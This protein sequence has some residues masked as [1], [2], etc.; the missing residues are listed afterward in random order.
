MIA[1][2]GTDSTASRPLACREMIN[3]QRTRRAVVES[4]WRISSG[5]M[6][7]GERGWDSRWVSIRP[8]GRHCPHLTGPKKEGGPRAAP[9]NG[10]VSET[11]SLLDLVA[12][13]APETKRLDG[14]PRHG[15]RPCLR[16]VTPKVPAAPRAAARRQASGA[17]AQ[18]FRV[19]INLARSSPKNGRRPG[20]QVPS[21]KDVRRNDGAVRLAR[22]HAGVAR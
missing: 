1:P 9:C 10:A 22:T 7:A 6:P 15:P 12:P 3:Q 14:S 13:K 16:L 4:D 8:P 2:S 18:P 11:R 17:R 21:N 19:M 5:V 20:E